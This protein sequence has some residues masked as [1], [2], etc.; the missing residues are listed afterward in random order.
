MRYIIIIL[1]SVFLIACSTNNS[2]VQNT[3]KK[4]ETIDSG[5]I[6]ISADISFKPVIDEQLKVFL[7]SNPK[8]KVF[9]EYKSEVDCFKD[10][11]NDSTRLIIVSRGLTKQESNY[12]ENKISFKPYYSKVAYD[13]VAAIINIK[14]T[15]SLFTINDLKNILLGKKKYAVVLDGTNATST[16]KYLQDSVL[17]E[18]KF[19]TNV[20]AV[21]GSDSVIETIKKTQNAIGFVSNCW[22]SNRYDEK[23]V[24]NLQQMKLALI[25][26]VRCDEKDYYAKASQATLQY[27]QYPLA[28]PIYYIVKENYEGLGTGFGRFLSSE[29]G[30]LI[31]K[32]SCVVPA[33]MNFNKRQT[34]L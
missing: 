32:R 29:R 21:N 15:D 10:F 8:A 18:A 4:S 16:V 7:A 34:K 3:N 20:V 23:Q 2:S 17:R 24:A 26:C 31:F 6:R 27:G 19:G 28:R 14:N 22:V 12:F 9:I 13:A 25:E 30:Q 33:L 1:F 11:I 5:N